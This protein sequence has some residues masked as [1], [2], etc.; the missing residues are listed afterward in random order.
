MQRFL[1]VYIPSS[2]VPEHPTDVD[3][4]E[5]QLKLPTQGES[6]AVPTEVKIQPVAPAAN[7]V[8]KE[9]R[10]PTYLIHKYLGR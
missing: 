7:L 2:K 1:G 9:P 6:S 8:A 10:S 4:E 3:N 5:S